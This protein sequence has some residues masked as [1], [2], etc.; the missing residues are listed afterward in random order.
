[1]ILGRKKKKARD[2][3]GAAKPPP[4]PTTASNPAGGTRMSEEDVLWLVGQ[5]VPVPAKPIPERFYFPKLPGR[6]PGYKVAPLTDSQAIRLVKRH[7]RYYP[8]FDGL[9]PTLL[10]LVYGIEG[11]TEPFDDT[12]LGGY[13]IREYDLGESVYDWEYVVPWPYRSRKRP[14]CW[15]PWF[16][17]PPYTEDQITRTKD[18]E[19]GGVREEKKTVS[20]KGRLRFAVLHKGSVGVPALTLGT[21]RAVIDYAHGYGGLGEMAALR[22][23]ALERAIRAEG[24]IAIEGSRLAMKS[25]DEKF[26]DE[27]EE[28]TEQ[29]TVAGGIL[30]TLDKLKK[31]DE[32]GNHD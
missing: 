5:A 8:I 30:A 23:V 17:D 1:M 10:R 2:A 4:V 27:A 21:Y 20:A 19:T 7:G 18:K 31:M 22:D 16:R 26:R 11:S 14:P 15:H 24:A 9:F 6:E 3:S 29:P 25:Y 28:G 32:E 12:L 13:P